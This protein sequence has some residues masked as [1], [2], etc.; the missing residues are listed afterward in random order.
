M[1]SSKLMC[2][3]SHNFERFLADGWWCL[4][5]IGNLLAALHDNLGISSIGKGQPVVEIPPIERLNPEQVKR[6]LMYAEVI[7]RVK[8][9]SNPERFIRWTCLDRLLELPMQANREILM[10]NVTHF[11]IEVSQRHQQVEI[12]PFIELLANNQLQQI[13]VSPNRSLDYPRSN[14]NDAEVMLRALTKHCGSQSSLQWFTYYP[15]TIQDAGSWLEWQIQQFL[16]L[17]R[18]LHIFTTSIWFFSEGPPVLHVNISLVS[19]IMFSEGAFSNL[20][21]LLLQDVPLMFAHD[22]LKAQKMIDQV[23]ILRLKICAI[24]ELLEEEVN[25]DIPYTQLLQRLAAFPKLQE[26]TFISARTDLEAP[27]PFNMALLEPVLQKQL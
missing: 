10:P 18:N 7:L 11:S 13:W 23:A 8:V 6:F 12:A 25:E 1:T 4:T 9:N 17:S 19:Q 21:M 27:Y 20:H 14:L 24:N 26:L 5:G 2:T 15:E 3:S 16:P 22:L